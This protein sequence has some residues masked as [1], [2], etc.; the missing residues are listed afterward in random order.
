M[1]TNHSHYPALFQPLDLKHTIL[2]NRVVMGSMHTGLEEEKNGFTKLAAFYAERAQGGVALIVT[3]GIAPNYA[4]RLSPFAAKL[5]THRE[6]RK[7]QQI[8]DA[9]HSA[10]GKILLQILHAGR[11]A[12]HPL[13]VSASAIKSPISPFKPWA[14]PAYCVNK[15]IDHFV[16]CA[17]LAK[18]AGYDGVEIMGSEGYLL[19]QFIVNHT[20]HRQDSFGGHFEN[21]IRLPI[22]IVQRIREACGND[23][24]I[25]YRLSMLDLIANGSNL[26]EVLSLAK[27][28]EKAGA[29]MINTGIGWHEA[30]IPTIAMMVPRGFFSPVTQLL[31]THV[32]IPIITSNRINTPEVA[33]SILQHNL[34]DMVS[35]ARPLLADPDFVLK[36]Q[37]GKA[38]SINTCIACN[39]A[40]LDHIFKGKLASCL[41]NPRACRELELNYRPTQHP[42]KLAV[43]GAGPAGLAFAITSAQ[44]GHH[45]VLFEKSDKIGGQLNIAKQIPGKEEF[46]ET[47]RYFDHQLKHYAVAV[48]LNQTADVSLLTHENFSEVILATG[49]IPNVPHIPGIHHPKVLTYIDVLLHKKPVGKRVAIIGAG[50]IGIDTAIYLANGHESSSLQPQSFA[51]EWGIDLSLSQRGGLQP[52]GPSFEASPHTI[53]LLQRKNGKIGADLGKT[54]G[55]IHRTTLKHKNVHCLSGVTYQKID[56]QGLHV[57]VNKTPHILAV[58]S[59]ILCAGQQA[60]RELQQPLVHHKIPTHLVGGASLAAELD[61]KRAI[62]ESCELASKI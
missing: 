16:R 10:E 31:R 1:S 48:R 12:Y 23:F 35:M 39:Q 9:V 20:N 4:G 21:R 3:G 43:I 30:R 60:L 62:A 19:N 46:H 54:T 55:W 59:I 57:L 11:Y 26:D 6:A 32:S 37:Q 53:Y 41:V 38:A 18:A 52:Q 40:C 29:S 51:K 50:G 28:I 33:E 56:D 47:L 25:M 34:A 36:A 44:R 45:V 17:L 49:V 61:A 8:T 42:K 14:L 7:H 27:H 5:S 2:K 15:T 58:D 22:T 24:I 13:A